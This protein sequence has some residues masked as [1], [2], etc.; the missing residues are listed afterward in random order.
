MLD[1]ESFSS[2]KS[3]T[4]KKAKLSK[5]HSNEKLHENPN[6]LALDDKMK[7]SEDSLEND[8]DITVE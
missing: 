8:I 5:A 6:L 7:Y 1:G 3:K 2:A 4:E